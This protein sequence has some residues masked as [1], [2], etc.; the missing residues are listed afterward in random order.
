MWGDYQ[1]HERA[2]ASI[3]NQT[4]HNNKIMKMISRVNITT[5]SHG[6]NRQTNNSSDKG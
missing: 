2:A 3:T 4:I 5:N 6:S 1:H